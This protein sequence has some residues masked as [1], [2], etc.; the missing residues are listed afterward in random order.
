MKDIFAILGVFFLVGLLLVSLSDDK[1]SDDQAIKDKISIIALAENSDDPVVKS[2]GEIAKKELDDLQAAKQQAI[3][4]E[5]KA[6]A[7]E[8]KEKA[9]RAAARAEL[10]ASPTG[11]FLHVFQYVL[12]SILVVGFATIFFIRMSRPRYF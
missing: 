1:E 2:Q 7:E 10:Q 3:L 6:E 12:I 8:A 5:K 4:E 9:E 11:R